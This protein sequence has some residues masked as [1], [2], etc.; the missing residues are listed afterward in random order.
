[1][2][3]LARADEIPARQHFLTEG[4][5]IGRAGPGLPG[6]QTRDR[7]RPNPCLSGEIG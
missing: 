6:A 7:D 1:M 3:K 2:P 4:H 5:G